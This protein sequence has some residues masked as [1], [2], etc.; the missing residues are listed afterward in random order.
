M[1][2]ITQLLQISTY[3]RVGRISLLIAQ[4]LTRLLSASVE[5]YLRRNFGRRYLVTITLAW[6][7]YMMCMGF[8]PPAMPLT[9]LFA[10]GLL[11]LSFHHYAFTFSRRRLQLPEPHSLSSGDSW[12]FWRSLPFQPTTVQQCIEPALCVLISFPVAS[13]DPFLALWLRASAIALFAKELITRMST[14]RRIM[15]TADARIEAQRLNAGLNQHLQ[16]PRNGAQA[17]H[18]ARFPNQAPGRRRNP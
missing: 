5:I 17:A 1:P 3:R 4:W 14:T 12:E 18:R 13:V 16:Q 2:E 10:L 11:V 9:G 7:F 6:V 15:D 8:A